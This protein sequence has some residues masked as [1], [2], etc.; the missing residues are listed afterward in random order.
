MSDSDIIELGE[1]GSFDVPVAVKKVSNVNSITATATSDAPW[2]NE[3]LAEQM[4]SE[5]R[6]DVQPGEYK[7]VATSK[8][9]VCIV[10]RLAEGENVKSIIVKTAKV[11]VTT[12]SEQVFEVPANAVC[13]NET[14]GQCRIWGSFAFIYFDIL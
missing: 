6:K 5:L 3:L 8:N 4:A 10:F 12:T 7:I 13:I 11:F 14:S 9:H 2:N 1:D